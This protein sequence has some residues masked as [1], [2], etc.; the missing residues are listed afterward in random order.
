MSFLL[1]ISLVNVN[2]IAKKRGFVHIYQKN[3]YGKHFYALFDLVWNRYFDYSLKVIT[4]SNHGVVVCK[5][6]IS[7]DLL[8]G[9]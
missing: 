4:R 3:P 9:S 8:L 5:K 2:K 6:V 7:K 1:I